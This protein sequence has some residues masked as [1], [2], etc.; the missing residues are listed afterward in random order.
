MSGIFTLHQD[1]TIEAGDEGA[2]VESADNADVGE[3]ADITGSNVG[4]LV[5]RISATWVE[6]NI[7]QRA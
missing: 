1:G 5:R 4:R 3:A 2:V 6:V 7:G